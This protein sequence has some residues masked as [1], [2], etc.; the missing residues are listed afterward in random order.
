MR[1][2]IIPA[3]EK[4][5]REYG[6][7]MYNLESDSKNL[8]LQTQSIYENIQDQDRNFQLM[9]TRFAV[10]KKKC[11]E[12]VLAQKHE[13]ARTDDLMRHRFIVRTEHIKNENAI[14]EEFPDILDAATKILQIKYHNPHEQRQYVEL[15]ISIMKERS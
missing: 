4:M 5:L 10:W 9:Q 1:Q 12:R 2:Y 6:V 15:L 3:V 8:Q 13:Q 7:F 14:K 11:D